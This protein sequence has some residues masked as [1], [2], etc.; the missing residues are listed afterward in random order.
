MTPFEAMYGRPPP[1]VLTYASGIARVADV[2]DE[3]MQCDETLT[4]LKD[5]LELAQSRMK[6]F[7][8]LQWKEMQFAM[9]EWVLLKLHPYRQVSLRVEAS[10][11]FLP[12]L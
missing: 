3:L 8:D 7:A 5:N 1:S 6:H 4:L 10:K 9:G 11:A 12:F 2:E